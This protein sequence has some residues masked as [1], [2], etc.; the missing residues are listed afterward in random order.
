LQFRVCSLIL[1]DDYSHSDFFPH[2]QIDT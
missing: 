2:F 1:F